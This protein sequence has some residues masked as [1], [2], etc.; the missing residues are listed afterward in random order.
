MTD[1]C[2]ATNILGT[3]K[4]CA[5]HS[6]KRHLVETQRLL[7]A[8]KCPDPDCDG[9]G[10]TMIVTTGTTA[11]CCG[12]PLATGECCGNPVPEPIQD[13]EPAPC[14]WCYERKEILKG[15]TRTKWYPARNKKMKEQ[16]DG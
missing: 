16:N 7:R 9:E 6:I 11:G 5:A 2:K 12:V 8:A 14:Q 3:A 15:A 10:M 4:N 1:E 13:F